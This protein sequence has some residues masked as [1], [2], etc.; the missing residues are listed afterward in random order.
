MDVVLSV[1]AQSDAILKHLAGGLLNKK[2]H[3]AKDVKI[4]WCRDKAR[5]HLAV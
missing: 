2:L 5:R 1:S 4:S 3:P